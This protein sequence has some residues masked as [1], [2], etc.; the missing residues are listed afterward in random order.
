M[1]S[2]IEL[3]FLPLFTELPTTHETSFLFA[4]TGVGQQGHM[5]PVSR[6]Q[7]AFVRWQL[8]YDSSFSSVER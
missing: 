8:A 4:G 5:S 3:D 2:T 1:Q 7:K 6:Y